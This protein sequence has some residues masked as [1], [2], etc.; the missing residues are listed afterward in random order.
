MEDGESQALLS[1]DPDDSP[2]I[3]RYN[4]QD[5]DG[6]VV[7]ESKDPTYDNG[8]YRLNFGGR[9]SVPSIKNFQMTKADENNQT[10]VQF[11]KVAENRFHLDFR[12]PVTPFQALCMALAQFTL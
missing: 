3:H 5:V 4:L 1:P 11:G 12:G 2:L 9:V 6:L 7:F 8:C 10:F